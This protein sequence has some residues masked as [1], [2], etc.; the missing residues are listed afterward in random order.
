[1]RMGSC[2]RQDTDTTPRLT[3]GCAKPSPKLYE[4]SQMIELDAL[5]PW[6]KYMMRLGFSIGA[7]ILHSNYDRPRKANM[8]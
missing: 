3:L 8:R 6:R 5:S 1:M 7:T 2:V 4:H